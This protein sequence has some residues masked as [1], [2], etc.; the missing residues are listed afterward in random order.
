MNSENELILF[1]THDGEVSL[2]VNI[3]VGSENVW[4]SRSQLAELYGRDSK[5]IG[6]HI[7]NALNEELSGLR[8]AT[9]AKF[10]TVQTEGTRQVERQI[11]HY[12]LDVILSVG[13]RVKSQRGVEFRRWATDVLRRYVLEGHVENERRLAQLGEIARIIERL[14]ETI[15]SHQILDIIKSYTYA[16]DLLDDYDHQS[17]S[18]PKGSATT[19]VLSYDECRAV[20]DNMR[21]GAESDLFGNEKDDSFK[22]SIGAICQSFDGQDLYPSAQRKRRTCCTSWLRI[23]R[24]GNK[25]I[26]AALFLYF[27]NKNTLLYDDGHKLLADETLVAI[28][29]MIAESRPEEKETMVSLVMNFLA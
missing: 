13:Y 22:G 23:T 19:Y 27:L 1:K 3:D 18:R 17:L 15:E 20:I 11:E 16:L 14:P 7:N 2:P 4:L 10:A 28:T 24:S 8:K 21:F 29:I 25:R 26:A 5:T 12:N 6:K 9:V